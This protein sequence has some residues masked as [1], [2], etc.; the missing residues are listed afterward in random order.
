M[1]RKG[2]IKDCVISLRCDHATKEFLEHLAESL[3]VSVSHLIFR[4]IQ[5]GVRIERERRSRLRNLIGG[6]QQ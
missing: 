2:P 6:G 4:L 1:T 5:G 3:D